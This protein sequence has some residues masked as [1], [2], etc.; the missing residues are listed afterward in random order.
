MSLPRTGGAGGHGC[1]YAAPY[2][3]RPTVHHGFPPI[4]RQ[5]WVVFAGQSDELHVKGHRFATESN[6]RARHSSTIHHAVPTRHRHT[7]RMTTGGPPKHEP[8]YLKYR[9]EFAAGPAAED[10]LITKMIADLLKNNQYQYA[11]SVKNT[12]LWRNGKAHAIRDAHSK[13][14]GILQGELTVHADIPPNL[15]QGMF[16]EPGRTYPVIARISTTSGAIRSDQ[17]RGVRGLGI[18]VLGVTGES[19]VRAHEAFDDS[20]QDFVFVTEPAFL[21]RDAEHYAG[22]GMTTAKTLARI[23][24]A[25]MIA[26]NTLLRTVR[27][28]VKLTGRDLP[29]TVGV[30]A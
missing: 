18:K 30:F 27:R 13:S 5:I 2:V 9:P 4:A 17:V 1:S 7:Y 28:V 10:A 15:R 16:A 21:F 8:E 14:C 19:G 12:K 24:D 23:P 26:V 6:R 29:R 3:L 22:A 11:K 20:N 25:G